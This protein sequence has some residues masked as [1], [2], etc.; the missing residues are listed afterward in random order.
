MAGR[1]WTWRKAGSV[2]ED[3]LLHAEKLLGC[4]KRNKNIT[5][6]LLM[7]RVGSSENTHDKA[8]TQGEDVVDEHVALHDVPAVEV[9]GSSDFALLNEA[10]NDFKNTTR[11]NSKANKAVYRHF[12]RNQR[13]VDTDFSESPAFRKKLLGVLLGVRSREIAIEAYAKAFG[14]EI[15]SSTKQGT[16]IGTS[17]AKEIIH[18]SPGYDSRFVGREDDRVR[19]IPRDDP[20]KDRRKDTTGSPSYCLLFTNNLPLVLYPYV[21]ICRHRP[22]MSVNHVLLL[23]FLLIVATTTS[24]GNPF[25]IAYANQQC[26]LSGYTMEVTVHSCQPRKISVNTCVGTCVSS[27]LPAAGLRIEPACTCC[28]EIESHE[29]EVGLWCQ[30]SPNSAWTQEYHVIKT[31]TKC[32]CRPC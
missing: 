25:K 16:A 6:G 22:T 19:R 9:E 27:A 14:E 31:A 21:N 17:V 3:H 10:F 18:S 4:Q 11:S 28:Q 15:L 8:S 30:A 26:K 12:D 32:A 23:T 13:A 29:V 24:R 2:L 7:P 20:L 1:A 5:F